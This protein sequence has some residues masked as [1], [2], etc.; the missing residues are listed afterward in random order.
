MSM[1]LEYNN[2]V[3]LFCIILNSA[4][5]TWYVPQLA[6]HAISCMQ[7]VSSILTH[8]IRGTVVLGDAVF[9]AL[10]YQHYLNVGAPL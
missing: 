8:A 9:H 3:L 1:Q 5:Y 2:C 6:E 4:G 7:V 10:C